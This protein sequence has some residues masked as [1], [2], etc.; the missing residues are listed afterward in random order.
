MQAFHKGWTNPLFFACFCMLAGAGCR[1]EGKSTPT[2]DS[3]RGD[4]FRV[5]LDVR[6]GESDSEIVEGIRSPD[7]G[8]AGVGGEIRVTASTGDIMLTNAALVTTPR[9]ATIPVVGV[10]VNNV[11]SGRQVT[12][13]GAHV[14]AFLNV[15]AGGT[16]VLEDDT[17]F[18]VLG[19]VQIDGTIRISAQSGNAIDGKDLTI[20]AAGIINITGLVDCSGYEG[21]D[22]FVVDEPRGAGGNGGEI[23]IQSNTGGSVLGPSIFISGRVFANGGDTFATDPALARP[24]TGGQILIGTS[25]TI[26]VPGRIS[27]RGGF[28]HNQG[29]LTGVVARGGTLELIALGDPT[30][31]P[32]GIEIGRVREVSASGGKSSGEGG[33]GGT[34]LLEA[35]AGTVSL[36]GLSVQAGGGKL[37][38]TPG[39]DAGDGGNVRINATSISMNNADIG[40]SGG[41]ALGDLDIDGGEKGGVVGGEGGQGGV[42]QMAA[43]LALTVAAD[44]SLLAE[45]GDSNE[46]GTPGGTGGQISV[47]SLDEAAP[48]SVITFDGSA[49]VEG[50][51]D[52]LGS[53]GA[54]GTICET[55]ADGTSQINLLG[56]NNFP[57]SICGPAQLD[58]LVVHDLDCDPLTINPE[59]TTTEL[60]AV[61]GVDFY[62]VR[63]P[64]AS[65]ITISVSGETSGNLSLFAGPEGVFGSTNVLDYC[66]ASVN[67]GS[68]EEIIIDVD[69]LGACP[70]L[71][72]FISIFVREDNNF[73]EE[74]TI[75]VD[76]Q[77]N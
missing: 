35:I 1:D 28:S 64:L 58:G 45:G 55:G 65:T 56:G 39:S 7:E 31:I 6:G 63:Y 3:V 21:I 75:T 37:T 32:T 29:S 48:L 17:S 9:V 54:E 43:S 42:V 77:T 57:I 34:V 46:S 20:E 47:I 22:F 27:A 10:S 71:G 25:G 40:A 74:Y 18:T 73:V 59:M 76:C 11:P 68:D 16:L 69:N 8:D 2:G 38:F 30:G 53:G 61:T 52:N 33:S 12:V 26:S 67:P 4:S 19:D 14:V 72:N 62:R 50:G 15:A 36:T 44:S 60:P 41:H 13:S 24:G 70:A 5:S 66:A 51:R 49:S 23:Y